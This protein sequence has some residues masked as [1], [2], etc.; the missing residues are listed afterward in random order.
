M[1]LDEKTTEIDLFRD[2]LN[3]LKWRISEYSDSGRPD[4]VYKSPGRDWGSVQDAPLHEPNLPSPL[5]QPQ[6]QEPQKRF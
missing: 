1:A 3:L 6:I 2:R 5:P 4:P